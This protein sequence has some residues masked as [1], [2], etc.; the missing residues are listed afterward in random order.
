MAKIARYNGDV[1]A[2]G[3]TAAGTDRTIFGDVTQSDTLDDNLNANFLKGWGILTAGAKPPKQYFNGALYT[4]TQFIAYLHEV[5]IPEWNT[6]QKYYIGSRTLGSDGVEYS[7][8]TGI[9]PSPNTGTN[10][11]TV[12]DET[13]W[14]I[15]S[16]PLKESSVAHDITVD[17]DYT[18]TALQNK[19]GRITISDT[20]IILTV[21]R[22]I[23]VDNTQRRFIFKNT[24]AQILTVKTTAGTGIAVSPNQSVELYNDGTNVIILSQSIGVN[25]SWQDVTVSRAIGVVY[26]NT[27]GKPIEV[28]ISIAAS[29]TAIQRMGLNIDGVSRGRWFTSSSSEVNALS[30]IIPNGSTYSIYQDTGT[31]LMNQWSELR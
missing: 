26:T 5:G 8:V 27:T 17:A 15:A 22:N 9:D 14:K 4:A 23:I 30:A 3:S 25:Q 18:L 31:P 7:S 10:P 11:T 1:R 24:T 20:G 13:V 16:N 21:A 19:Y 12:T 29:A 6:S 2:F 28:L